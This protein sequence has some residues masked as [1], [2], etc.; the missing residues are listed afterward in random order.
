[1]LA[2]GRFK[3]PLLGADVELTQGAELRLALPI[4]SRGKHPLQEFGSTWV[5]RRS[6]NPSKVG[7]YSAGTHNPVFVRRLTLGQAIALSVEQ[8]AGTVFTHE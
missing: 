2:T 1:M 7:Q 5:S 3:S 6:A 8:F 4:I